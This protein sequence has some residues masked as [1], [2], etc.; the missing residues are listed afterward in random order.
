M[1]VAPRS[2][3]WARRV[4]QWRERNPILV[5][6]FLLA[7][8]VTACSVLTL[9]LLDVYDRY[10]RRFNWREREYA[11]LEG[12]RA[13][14][15]LERFRDALG[16]PV[17]RRAARNGSL[18][19]SSF[20]GR[21]YWVQT[22]S[23]RQ[24]AVKAFAVTSCDESF[25]PTLVGPV[26]L[27]VTLQQSTLA[28]VAGDD[29]FPP[30]VDVV[31]AIGTTANTFLFDVLYGGNPTLYKSVAWGANDACPPPLAT[32]AARLLRERGLFDFRGSVT[33]R[34]VLREIQPLVTVNTYAETAP[35]VDF[36]ELAP[37]QI[38]VDRI[39]TRTA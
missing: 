26:D 10:D 24:G 15:Q 29:A 21:D 4:A 27:R 35:G 17:F 38:G 37:F 8:I 20:R 33:R 11:K 16:T 19:E 36:R 34:P 13:G 30:D 18:L 31:L 39:L 12:L 2:A 1:P 3:R 5:V 28:S 14:F 7:S 9:A 22:I 23:D 32:R 6:L 25:R